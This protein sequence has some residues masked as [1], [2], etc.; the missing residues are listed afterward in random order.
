MGNGDML[1]L[2]IELDETLGVSRHAHH[3]LGG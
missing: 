1:E 2:D 3:P